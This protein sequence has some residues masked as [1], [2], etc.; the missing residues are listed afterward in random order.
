MDF[1]T[2][3]GARKVA[4]DVTTFAG[5]FPI[6]PL[7]ILPANSHFI[8]ARDPILVDTN[9]VAFEDQYL[10][11]LSNV[12]DPAD[13]KWIYIS[14]TDL[15]HVGNLDKVMALAPNAKV[16]VPS[17]GA[18]KFGL[19]E[20]FDM[21]RLVPMDHGQRLDLGDREL[22]LLKPPTYDAPE[23]TG[24]FDTRT[25]V[26]FSVDSFGALL[27]APHEE[28][29]AIPEATLRDGM[30]MW[31]GIDAPWL[32]M[33]DK[34]R[35]GGLLNDIQRLDPSTIISGHLPATSG[36]MIGTVLGNMLGSLSEDRFQHPDR[37]TIEG[38]FAQPAVA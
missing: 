19:R 25:R 33:V 1:P 16:V 27:D 6:G 13:L 31:A 17:L 21:S 4:P 7:G 34:S 5:F 20:S 8:H 24:F 28:T 18:A 29:E 12:I 30:T 32:G 37:E 36:R 2:F 15:D 22:V 35:L 11:A 3:V 26:L 10:E 14:H 38:L 9:G 23:T